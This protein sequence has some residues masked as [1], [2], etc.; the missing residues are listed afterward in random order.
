M[1]QCF[2]IL[3][4][5]CSTLLSA[6]T[7]SRSKRTVSV[8]SAAVSQKSKSAKQRPLRE[9]TK[10][11]R[12]RGD[13]KTG[14]TPATPGI[15]R[16][17]NQ[18]ADLKRQI[19]KSQSELT[20]TRRNVSTQLATL[21][22][23]NGQINEQKK[24]VTGIQTQI[25]TLDHRIS[26]HEDEL[27]RLETDLAECKRK[28]LRG[29]MYMFR[30]RMTQ[31]KLMFMFSAQ[32]FRQMYRRLR[33]TQEYTK[34]Q[35]VQGRIIAAKE[36]LVRNKRTTLKRERRTQQDLLARGRHQQTFLEG[37]QQQKQEVVDE[38]NRQQRELQAT[39][40]RQQ[41]Q[42]QALNVR[43]DQLIRTEIAAA[44]ARQKAEE[45]KRIA[46]TAA[47][48]KA[49]ETR[50]KN[51]AARRKA[52]VEAQ[53]AEQDA[54]R[55]AEI[56]RRKAEE[57]RKRGE[58]R[59]AQEARAAQA[60]EEARAAAEAKRARRAAAQK[61]DTSIPISGSTHSDAGRLSGGFA[62]QRGRL[63]IPITG[64]Y[65][66]SAHF[67]S[68]NVDGLHGVTLDNKGINLTSA[69]PAQARCVYDG[70]VT[71]IFGMGGM[72]N[73]IVRHGTYI[74]VYC[75][76]SGISVRQGQHVGARQTLGSVARDASGRYTLH[77]QLR[78]E[79]VKLNPETWLGR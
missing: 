61:D 27:A 63:P 5:I 9:N 28:Y 25:D 16:L 43:I 73:V 4:L 45:K 67:G 38:L 12:K 8:H 75:N 13:K 37:Q 71:A 60:R 24:V 70:E 47:H 74:S 35:R 33:Y 59:A 15:R 1:R 21:Q 20:V 22:I 19:A 30:N 46:A 39:L 62:A 40:A 68:Y 18:Q 51:E 58:L 3:F 48:R 17:K 42:Y 56:N 50:R 41:Q 77:F 69:A 29:V 53:K 2:L 79:T 23:L 6:Q 10:N 44:E 49:E 7:K 11:V 52:I 32:N 66:I 57:A 64:A 65:T 36:V 31:N 76:L 26:K 72:N 14:A 55:K 78:Q 34:Y 54:R